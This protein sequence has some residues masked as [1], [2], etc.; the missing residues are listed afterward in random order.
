MVSVI[1]DIIVSFETMHFATGMGMGMSVSA[2]S[3]PRNNNQWLCWLY[4]KYNRTKAQASAATK[5]VEVYGYFLQS[6]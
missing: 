4:L 3:T 1:L 6:V 5:A 2:P